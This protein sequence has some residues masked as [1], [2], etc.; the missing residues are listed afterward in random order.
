MILGNHTLIKGDELK[1]ARQ[2][3]RKC[4][5]TDVFMRDMD[6]SDPVMLSYNVEARMAQRRLHKHDVPDQ[7]MALMVDPPEDPENN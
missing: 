4:R 1:H 5:A 3:H 7:V 6:R 2:C